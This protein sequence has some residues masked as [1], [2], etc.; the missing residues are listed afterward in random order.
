M[1]KVELSNHLMKKTWGTIFSIIGYVIF[2]FFLTLFII[3][4]K[5]KCAINRFNYSR[6]KLRINPSNIRDSS[7]RLMNIL[8]FH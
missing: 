1:M 5:L 7:G 3:S 8:H 4:L 2:T 6:L